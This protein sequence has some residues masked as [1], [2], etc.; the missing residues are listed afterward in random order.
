[1]FELGPSFHS[2]KHSTP[3]CLLIMTRAGPLINYRT[4][5]SW[6]Q[7]AVPVGRLCL[8]IVARRL[9]LLVA[10]YVAMPKYSFDC[11]A[12]HHTGVD[13]PD[14]PQLVFEQLE[15]SGLW[16]FEEER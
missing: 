6:S 12:T 3:P 11:S 5:G 4:L 8:R 9:I 16:R 10:E 15:K 14:S 13:E 7:L 1:M 2:K